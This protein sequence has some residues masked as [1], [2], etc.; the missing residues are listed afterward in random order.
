VTARHR[1][2]VIGEWLLNVYRYTLVR[3]FDDGRWKPRKL[4]TLSLW[5]SA[6]MLTRLDSAVM[7]AVILPVSL[8]SALWQAKGAPAKVAGTLSLV[9]PLGLLVG[10]WLIWKTRYYGDILPN[11]YYVKAASNPSL[12]RGAM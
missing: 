5:L 10:A 1:S 3:S 2:T 11:T 12:A 4:I 8:A 7:V 6:A 9:L